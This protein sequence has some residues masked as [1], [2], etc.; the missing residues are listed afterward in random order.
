MC[1]RDST[2]GSYMKKNENIE[3]NALIIPFADTVIAIMAGLAVMPAVFASGLD[4]GQGPGL[5]FVTLQTVFQAMG[6]VGPIFGF[7]LYGLVFIAAITSSIALLEAVSAVIM[8]KRAEKGKPINR[9]MTTTIMGLIVMAEA[10]FVSL[11][12]LGAVSYTHLVRGRAD[13]LLPVS[14][15]RLY[16]RLRFLSGQEGKPGGQRH[17]GA[18]L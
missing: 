7:L 9:K 2:Y 1:I 16:D 5:L 14:G 3:R 15:V 11:D 12:G 6:S 4:P 17:S 13:L 8:D 18:Y 10:V